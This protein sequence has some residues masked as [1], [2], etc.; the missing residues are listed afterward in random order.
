MGAACSCRPPSTPTAVKITTV[1]L[2]LPCHGDVRRWGRV[3][4]K[5]DFG[6]KL[7]T[8]VWQVWD[9]KRRQAEQAEKR[10]LR[11]ARARGRSASPGGGARPDRKWGMRKPP[12]PDQL[13]EH[14]ML[15]LSNNQR[16]VGVRDWNLG[17]CQHS[18]CLA[19]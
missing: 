6:D 7:A 19:A 1:C 17:H 9:E 15:K 8:R 10:R 14:D 12:A 11:R 18:L 13:G 4:I 2:Q 5:D 3:T 16:C